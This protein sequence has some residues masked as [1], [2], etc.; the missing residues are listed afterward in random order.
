[1]HPAYSHLSP[2]HYLAFLQQSFPPPFSLLPAP[3]SLL[4]APL[5]LLPAP[6]S[7]L[8]AP[9]SFLPAPLFKVVNRRIITLER[10]TLLLLSFQRGNRRKIRLCDR[11]QCQMSLSNKFT[12]KGTLQQV[13]I[14]LR[15]RTPYPPSYTLYKCIQY[16]Y[17]HKKGGR[18][19]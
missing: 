11:M 15:P 5:S 12:C 14:C 10:P 4:P 3:L 6:L 17:S 1:M 8:P 16:T 19:N 18:A 2:L 9:L 7:L 13:Y